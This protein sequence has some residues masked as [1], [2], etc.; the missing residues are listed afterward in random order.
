MKCCWQRAMQS[1]PNGTPS[2]R[3][4]DAV[5]VNLRAETLLAPSSPKESFSEVQ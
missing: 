2:H 4:R 1:V 3:P 5:R